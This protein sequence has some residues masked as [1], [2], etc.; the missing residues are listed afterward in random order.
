MGRIAMQRLPGTAFLETLVSREAV[1][2]QHASA[3]LEEEVEVVVEVDA[4]LLLWEP[5]RSEREGHL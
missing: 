4:W 1:A 3:R 5:S 2:M